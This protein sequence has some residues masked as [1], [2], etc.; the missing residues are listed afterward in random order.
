MMDIS[1]I[2]KE[3]FNNIDNNKIKE[4]I[5][6]LVNNL[7]NQ[8]GEIEMLYGVDWFLFDPL[9]LYLYAYKS[10]N[11]SGIEDAVKTFLLTTSFFSECIYTFSLAL[12]REINKYMKTCCSDIVKEYEKKDIVIRFDTNI[13][14]TE[15]SVYLFKPVGISDFSRLE[16]DDLIGRSSFITLFKDCVECIVGSIGKGGLEVQG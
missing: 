16:E 15:F 3:I 8:F 10:D 2:I 6:N 9:N 14:E 12:D 7:V 13:K 4:I 1:Q 5:S 11:E